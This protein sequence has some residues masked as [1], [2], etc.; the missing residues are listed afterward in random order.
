MSAAG[1]T[2]QR[3]GDRTVT[4]GHDERMSTA[5]APVLPAALRLGAVHVPDITRA[6]AWYERALGLRVHEQGET[7]AMLGDG[8]EV[9]LLLHQDREAQPAGRTAGLYHYALLYSSREEL[10]RAALRLSATQTPIQG[11]SDHETHEAIYLA[12]ADGNGIE[13]AA[14]RP[15]DTWPEHLGYATRPKPLDFEALMS[16]VAQEQSTPW[17]G[18]G[19]RIGHLHLHVGDIEEGL[20]F[21]RDTVGFELQANL[22]FAAFVSAGGYHHHLAFNVWNG[23][24]APAPPLHAVG[25]HAWSVELPAED[26]AALR[27]RL[28][29]A[30]HPLRDLPSGFLVRDPWDSAL[31][32]RTG[33]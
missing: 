7:L 20:R 11:A 12:D 3:R 24:D 31:V 18:E 13:L 19:L 1:G 15:R 29:A 10:A 21:Y 33:L 25:L 28:E 27:A 8:A 23:A 17:A 6:V 30:G 32:A 16:T 14:D 22:G 2:E 26:L 9:V 5:A 4:L